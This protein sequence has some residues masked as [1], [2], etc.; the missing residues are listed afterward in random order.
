MRQL[1]GGDVA[2]AVGAFEVHLAVHRLGERRSF[3]GD[4]LAVGALGVLVAVARE[5]RIVDAGRGGAC[6]LR[7][8]H[9]QQPEAEGPDKHSDRP[10][11]IGRGRTVLRLA[12]THWEAR[13]RSA[14]GPGS[15]SSGTARD[16]RRLRTH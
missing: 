5:A 10:D 8:A 13:D 11:P 1:L 9:R 16:S 2:V 6:A 4:R 14:E 7:D 15:R 3:D 12:A